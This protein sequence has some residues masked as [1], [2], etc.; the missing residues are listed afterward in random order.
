MIYTLSKLN[1]IVMAIICSECEQE[2]STTVKRLTLL[3]SND[4]VS[5]KCIGVLDAAR[6]FQCVC[7]HRCVHQGGGEGSGLTDLEWEMHCRSIFLFYVIMKS[8]KKYFRFINE[9]MAGQIRQSV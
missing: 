1:K 3:T 7:E 8:V 5:A 4:V 6:W 2:Q 9:T